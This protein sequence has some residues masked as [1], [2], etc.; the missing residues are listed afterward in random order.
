M[1]LRF[2]VIAVSLLAAHV[3]GRDDANFGISFLPT[4]TSHG[5]PDVLDDVSRRSRPVCAHGR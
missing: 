5:T 3:S 4:H 2:L 1:D